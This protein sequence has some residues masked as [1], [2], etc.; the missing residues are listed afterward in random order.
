MS[1]RP[2]YSIII[3]LGRE[4]RTRIYDR[5]T[6]SAQVCLHHNV[7]LFFCLFVVVDDAA[8]AA[9]VVVSF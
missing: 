4:I 8:A 2:P 5:N 3:L 6:Q 7:I 9:V 1:A